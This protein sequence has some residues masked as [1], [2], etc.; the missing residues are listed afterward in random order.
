MHKYIRQI[1]AGLG[2]LLG[3]V[4]IC[5]GIFVFTTFDL[6]MLWF[7]SGGVAMI[8]TALAN[9]RT[10]GIWILRVQNALMLSFVLALLMLTQ[11]PQ[12]F[13]GVVIFAGLFLISCFG[14]GRAD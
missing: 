7:L 6:D 10:G 5:F 13:S 12:I 1:L 8:V 9:L 2:V 11:Q 3:V 14:R 4:H